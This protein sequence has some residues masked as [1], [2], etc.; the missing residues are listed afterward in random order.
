M[1]DLNAMC[2]ASGLQSGYSILRTCNL[3]SP[4]NADVN[5]VPGST[6]PLPDGYS[7]RSQYSS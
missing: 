6:T 4:F 2:A 1:N 3:F 5:W 7:R